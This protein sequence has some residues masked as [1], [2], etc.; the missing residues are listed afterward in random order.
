L[1]AVGTAQGAENRAERLE[2]RSRPR[3]LSLIQKLNY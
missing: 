3:S 1:W 2:I